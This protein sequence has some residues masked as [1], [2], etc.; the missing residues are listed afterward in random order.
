MHV[1]CLL[2]YAMQRADPLGVMPGH[3]LL[4]FLTAHLM[5]KEAC[6]GKRPV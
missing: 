6:Q 2:E 4:I 5:Q 3:C 1:R